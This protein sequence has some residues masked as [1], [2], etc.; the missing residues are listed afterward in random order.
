MTT[1]L[2]EH[3]AAAYLQVPEGA[4]KNARYRKKVK[5]RK[6]CGVV[7]YMQEWLDEFREGTCASNRSS[8][9]VV[10]LPTGSSMSRNQEPDER[11][12]LAR[13]KLIIAK[14]NLSSRNGCS[15]AGSQS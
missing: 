5:S 11:A 10:T 3:E 14:Q 6:I 9:N 8:S 2:I 15:N 7:Q 13:A 4:L 12:A 1:W